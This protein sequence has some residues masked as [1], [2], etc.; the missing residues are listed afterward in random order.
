VD[1]LTALAVDV[2]ATAEEQRAGIAQIDEAVEQVGIVTQ[3]TAATAEEAS[4]S[5]TELASQAASLA[6]LVA[7][8]RLDAADGAEAPV[9]PPRDYALPSRLNPPAGRPA[10]RRRGASR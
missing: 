1:R 2:S 7:T 4:S 6:D 9:A 8:F 3:R 10:S 5:A